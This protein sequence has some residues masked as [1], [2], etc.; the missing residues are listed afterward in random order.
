MMENIF[1][2]LIIIRISLCKKVFW[3]LKLIISSKKTSQISEPSQVHKLYNRNS[4]E[5]K[6]DTLSWIWKMDMKWYELFLF[7]ISTR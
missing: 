1:G 5:I 4:L 7:Y 2:G 6:I 3:K